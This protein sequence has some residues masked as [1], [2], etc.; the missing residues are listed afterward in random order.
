MLT[1]NARYD[2]CD[3]NHA[4]VFSEKPI[5]CHLTR[6]ISWFTVS[7]VFWR[8]ISIIP[9]KSPFLKPFSILSLREERQ[10]SVECFTWEKPLRNGDITYFCYK[11]CQNTCILAITAPFEMSIN[12][13]TSK[14]FFSVVK[15]RLKL[16]QF[17]QENLGDS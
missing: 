11:F 5:A 1:L 14:T 10:R 13:K 12:Y 16:Y 15:F 8:S 3:L 9:V 4:T 2:K 6:R 17:C 7:K